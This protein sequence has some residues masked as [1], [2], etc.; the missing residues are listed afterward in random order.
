MVAP[1]VR[2][3]AVDRRERELPATVARRHVRDGGDLELPHTAASFTLAGPR[4]AAA[5]TASMTGGRRPRVATMT[6]FHAHV[7]LK[8]SPPGRANLQDGRP[9]RGKLA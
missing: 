1:K 9:P 7:D 8:L 3:S 6:G 2:L 4:V 5:A